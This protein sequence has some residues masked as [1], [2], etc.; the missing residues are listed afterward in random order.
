MRF[1]QRQPKQ[2][3]RFSTEIITLI[4]EMAHDNPLWGAERIRGELLKLGITVAKRTVQRYMGLRPSLHTTGQAWAS[5]LKTHVKDI[6]ACDFMPVI[7]L[8]FHRLFVFF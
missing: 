4:R 5:F 6:W 3:T 8:C 2:Q 1:K 7:D